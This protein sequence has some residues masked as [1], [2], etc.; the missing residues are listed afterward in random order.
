MSEKNLEEP[1]NKAKSFRWSTGHA[2]L[3][4]ICF[5]VAIFPKRKTFFCFCRWRIVIESLFNIKVYGEDV[6]E[7]VIILDFILEHLP[8]FWSI[9]IETFR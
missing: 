8:S 7:F 2:K 9:V 3:R 5:T 1:R 6:F 4:D